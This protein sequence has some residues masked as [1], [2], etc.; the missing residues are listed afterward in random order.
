MDA[1]CKGITPP[2]PKVAAEDATSAGSKRESLEEG[3][4]VATVFF[5][6]EMG[7]SV[8]PEAFGGLGMTTW[9]AAGQGDLLEPS[10]E[11]CFIKK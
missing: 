2:A 10:L 5:D 8:T 4:A 6:R 9:R 3:A 7:I 1:R 11:A